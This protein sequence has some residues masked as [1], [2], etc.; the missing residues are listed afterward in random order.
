MF[1]LQ[2][3]MD[4]G[5][6]TRYFSC[7]GL[8]GPIALYKNADNNVEGYKCFPQSIKLKEMTDGCY[9]VFKCM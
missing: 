8:P 1:T 7:S 5:I 3:R 2:N 9:F 6:F 4:L